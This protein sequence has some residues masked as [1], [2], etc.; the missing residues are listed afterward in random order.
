MINDRTVRSRCVLL[1]CVFS[2]IIHP[3]FQVLIHVD[4]IHLYSAK[5]PKSS[6]DVDIIGE[7]PILHDTTLEICLEQT[8]RVL[9]SQEVSVAQ[10]K[11]GKT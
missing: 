4:N 1:S 2:T 9:E 5:L 11:L 8:Q 7:Q 6:T 3:N 10:S